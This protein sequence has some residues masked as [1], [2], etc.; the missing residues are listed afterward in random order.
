LITGKAQRRS[1]KRARPGRPGSNEDENMESPLQITLRNIPYSDALDA[2]IRDRVQRLERFYPRITSCQ[3]VV[4]MPHRHAHQGNLFNVRL[5]VKVPGNAFVLS[6]DLHE[7]VYVA[8]RDVF[9][10]ARRKLEDHGRRQRGSVKVHDALLTGT[11]SRRFPE[12]GYGF[13][14]TADGDEYYFSAANV[15]T[16]SFD[17]LEEGEVVHFIADLSADSPQ[18]KRVS[19]SRRRPNGA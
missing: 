16:P 13:I 10:A 1:T 8:L 18:A 4:E 6:R 5:D 2:H 11:V 7:D 12:E 15:V 3:V 17:R 14:E 19:A 9:D